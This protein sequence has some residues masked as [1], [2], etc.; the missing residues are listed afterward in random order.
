MAQPQKPRPN[1]DQRVRGPNLAILVKRANGVPFEQA[2]DRADREKK[3]VVSNK[4]MDS[5]L[6]SNEWQQVREGIWC[7]TGTMT[8][9]VGPDKAFQEASEPTDTI[10]QGSRSII[11]TDSETGFRHIFP[12]PEEH[13]EVRNGIL[14]TEHPEYKLTV[15]GNDRI[16]EPQTVSLV[17]GFPASDGWYLADTVHGIPTGEQVNSSNAD[18]RYL[19]RVDKRVGPVA[20]DYDFIGYGGW[21]V[22]YL[23]D[24]PSGGFGVVVE[25]ASGGAPTKATSSSTMKVREEGGKII[26]EGTS[27]QL[28]AAKRKLAELQ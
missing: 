27:E 9:Y 3:V 13:L 11:Y 21:R 20:R 24:R 8:G 22:V 5:A 6:Q 18:A 10:K 23:V 17:E 15:D 19:G 2:F 7:W 1:Q 4:R 16:V 14:V 25:A 26:V 28:A 12:I